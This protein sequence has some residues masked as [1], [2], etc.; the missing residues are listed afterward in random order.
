MSNAVTQG[1]PQTGAPRETR[2]FGQGLK[3]YAKRYAGAY[4]DQ[5]IGNMMTEAI[6]PSL[7]REDPRYFRRGRGGKWPRARYAM[8]RILV[9]RTDGRRCLRYLP[10]PISVPLVPSPATNTSTSG[11]SRKISGPVPS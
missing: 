4:G 1:I 5:A 8:S 2:S 7:L 9:T 6:F 11:Q 3:G 10:T